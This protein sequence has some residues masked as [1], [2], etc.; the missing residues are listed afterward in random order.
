[1]SNN[2]KKT[3]TEFEKYIA[4]CIA[5][6]GYWVHR[7]APG[8]GGAQP[9]DIIAIGPKVYAIDCKVCQKEVFDL[10]R[11]EENQIQAFAKIKDAAPDSVQ[12]FV[13]K[14]PSGIRQLSYTDYLNLA[15]SGVKQI[16]S[17]TL[18]DWEV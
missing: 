17:N 18:N 8:A 5:G 14:F 10:R 12:I 3:G 2:N 1:M 16:R 9:F 15:G 7:I 11:A 13:I 4:G 6:K